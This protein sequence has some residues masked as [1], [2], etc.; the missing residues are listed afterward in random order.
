LTFGGSA[1]ASIATASYTYTFSGGL[2]LGNSANV[3]PTYLYTA[4][5]GLSLG[6]SANAQSVFV[7]N[8]SG[9]LSLGN[10]VG[11]KPTYLYTASGGLTFGGTVNSLVTYTYAPSG[12]LSLGNSA[13]VQPTYLCTASG[14]L[15]LGNSANVQPTY[16]Y[17]ANGGLVFGGIADA[18]GNS[19][20]YP[21]SAS[22]GLSLSNSANVQ[23]TYLYAASG[24]L[25]LG[26]SA[27]VLPIYNLIGLGGLS[28]GNSAN[29]QPTY[30][31]TASGGL[32]FGSSSGV[33]ETADFYTYTFVG[34]LSLG[35]SADVKPKYLYTASGGLT[36]GSVA[37]GNL[38]FSFSGSG[39]LV[40]GESAIFSG[41]TYNYVCIG[42]LSLGSRAP[43]KVTSEFSKLFTWDVSRGVLKNWRVEGRCQPVDHPCPPTS[44]DSGC[45]SGNTMQYVVNVQAH[46][47]TDLCQKLK[48]RGWVI[49]IKRIQ[50]WSQPTNRSDWTSDVDPNCNQLITVN[51]SLVPDCID[52]GVDGNL[53]VTGKVTASLLFDV[54]FSYTASGGLGS[55]SGFVYISNHY[56]YTASGGLGS[57]SGSR[58]S[59]PQCFLYIASG[60]LSVSGLSGYY[61]SDYGI[62]ASSGRVSMSIMDLG[63]TFGEQA[64]NVLIPSTTEIST[65]CCSLLSLP[66]VLFVRHDLNRSDALTDFL[67]ING[68]VLPEIQT[69]M[70]SN[71]RKSWYGNLQLR[72]SSVDQAERQV[73]N[74]IFEFGCLTENTTLGIPSDVW[75]FSILVRRRGISSLRIEVSRLVLEFDSSQICNAPGVFQLDF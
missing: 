28:L 2:S 3:Q 59:S 43:F 62:L 47:L 71:Q 58:F 31:Y 8:V 37:T 42:G 22:G 54:S 69:M 70:Y 46:S 26:N 41:I 24:G 61:T 50:V 33:S 17:T 29:V 19:N 45:G 56:S 13:N 63:I 55:G 57:G 10:S 36:L 20:F 40:F 66:Q 18:A 73:W 21:Y 16:L 12:G 32:T 39:G 11:V 9:G 52:F 5:G 34:G 25:S 30:L 38:V 49:P 74:I 65:D 68:L 1:D 4:S 35:N 44:I 27:G 53:S 48:K 6:N 60:S 64:S 23:P 75:G 14:G 51:P 72:G 15:N 67:N 7:Y